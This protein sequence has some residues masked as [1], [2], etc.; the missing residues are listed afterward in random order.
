MCAKEVVNLIDC[1]MK[2]VELDKGSH[3]ESRKRY[4]DQKFSVPTIDYTTR[5]FITIFTTMK[6]RKNVDGQYLYDDNC[7]FYYRQYRKS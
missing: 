4:S 1:Q 6:V 7:S 3:R 2:L 5:T